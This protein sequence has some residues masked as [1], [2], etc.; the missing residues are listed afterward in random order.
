ME[1][2]AGPIADV[3]HAEE[4]EGVV[5]FG[6]RGQIWFTAASCSAARSLL[7]TWLISRRGPVVERM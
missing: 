6:K 3:L 7:R 5:G 1:N 4:R 2:A